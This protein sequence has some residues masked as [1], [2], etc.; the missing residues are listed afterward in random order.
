M[1]GRQSLRQGSSGHSHAPFGLG[2]LCGDDSPTHEESVV[3]T[4]VYKWVD[5]EYLGLQACSPSCR[6]VDPFTSSIAPIDL[7]MH[8]YI[9]YYLDNVVPVLHSSRIVF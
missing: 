6:G 3:K 1:R 5:E 8:T 9:Q 4:Q 2:Q 7:R